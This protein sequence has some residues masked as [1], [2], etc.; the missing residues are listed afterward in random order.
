MYERRTDSCGFPAETPPTR[1]RRAS[2][3]NFILMM[4]LKFENLN[5][6]ICKSEGCQ[7]F[8]G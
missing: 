4:W 1:A 2:D 7:L 3:V 6:Y 5:L 8:V